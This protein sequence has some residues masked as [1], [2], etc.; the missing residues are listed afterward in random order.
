M[1]DDG[2]SGIKYFYTLL[3]VQLLF[4]VHFEECLDNILKLV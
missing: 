3:F 4:C 1:L 2:A